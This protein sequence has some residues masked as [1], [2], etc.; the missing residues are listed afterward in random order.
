MRYRKEHNHEPYGEKNPSRQRINNAMKRKAE[1]KNID[2]KPAKT[3]RCEIAEQ[4]MAV[5]ILRP[6]IRE[7]VMRIKS[8]I[9]RKTLLRHC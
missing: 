1:E 6:A 8:S 2:E 7:D 3:N 9:I 4:E 5:P